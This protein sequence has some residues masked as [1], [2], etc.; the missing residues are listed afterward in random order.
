V[1][2]AVTSLERDL[3]NENVERVK[4]YIQSELDYLQGNN[5]DCGTKPTS[6][7]WAKTRL[8]RYPTWPMNR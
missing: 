3:A 4:Q 5:Q 7:C 8:F 1:T 2:P 6:L